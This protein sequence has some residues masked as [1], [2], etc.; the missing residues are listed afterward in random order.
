MDRRGG[1]MML[2]AE[3]PECLSGSGWSGPPAAASRALRPSLVERRVAQRLIGTCYP[4][5]S[6]RGAVRSCALARKTPQDRA[7]SIHF[8]SFGR[9]AQRLHLSSMPQ[10]APGPQ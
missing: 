8:E 3:G 6:V 9:V 10:C 1:A 2:S 4:L 7:A 5:H